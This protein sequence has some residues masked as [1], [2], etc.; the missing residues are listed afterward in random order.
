MHSK[1]TLADVAAAAGVSK[2]T[3][4]RA[5]R[6]AKDVS[7]KTVE[8]VRKIA[9]DLG[10]MGNHVAASLAN[11][12]TDLIGVVVPSL[13]NIVF[14]EVM[15]GI[16]DAI[17]GTGLQPFFGVTGYD[18]EREYLLVRQMLSWRPAGLIVTG[19]DQDAQ[20]RA[21]LKAA[22][23]PVVQIMDTDG[24]A[25]DLCV[26]F[27]QH[28][29]GAG[30]ADL[31]IKQDRKRFGYVGCALDRDTRAIK[32]RD[33]YLNTLAKNGITEVPQQTSTE[34]SSVAAGK[35]MTAALLA[36]HPS[37]DV[38]YYSNDDLAIGGAFHCM[39]RHIR[40]PDQVILAGFNGLD[41]V[42]SL[43]TPIATTRTS[44]RD[45]GT[46]AAKAI[47]SRHGTKVANDPLLK[48]VPIQHVIDARQT[49][50]AK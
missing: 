45:I 24:A 8:R 9:A 13:S 29:A 16:E 31:L 36:A 17:A 18:P 23:L 28:E 41:L 5:M 15:S 26:G 50:T 6:G 11:S 48:T 2:M 39:E 47:L 12:R 37:L 3:A 7:P 21:L 34:R 10:Y 42:A 30:M 19:L 32:R 40:V 43:P 44:R 35:T 1:V 4:S 14:S 22:T 33:G 25:V 27:S 49:V 38:I 46:A 20:T